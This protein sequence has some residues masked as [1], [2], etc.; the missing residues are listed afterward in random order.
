[1]TRARLSVGLVSP[2]PPVRSGIADYAKELVVPLREHV[3]LTTFAPAQAARAVESSCDVLLF[4]VGNDPL[5]LP[6]VEALR[7]RRKPAVVV[8]HD[9]VLHHLFA[10][11]YLDHGHLD[12][13]ER[14]LVRCHGLDGGEL[15]AKARSG[16]A[17]PVWDLSP[18]TFPMSAGVI[19][20]ATALLV[21]SRLVRG[22]VLRARPACHVVEIP[23]HVV[24]APVTPCDEARRRLGIPRDRPVAVT[25]GIVTPA[26]RVSKVLEALAA[27]PEA[28]RP[29]LVVGGAVGTEDPLHAQV[30]SLGLAADVLFTGYLSDDDFWV[31]ASAADLAVNLRHPTMGETSGAVCRLAGFGLPVVVSDV[32][33]FRELPDAFAIK[34][35]VGDGEVELLARTLASLGDPVWKRRSEAA[36]AWGLERSPERVAARYS[37]VLHDVAGGR[38]GEREL[39]AFLASQLSALGVGAGGRSPSRGPDGALLA[40]VAALAA[41]LLRA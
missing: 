27:V 34:V 41:P 37:E 40:G 7:E 29:F 28:S 1:V 26:K 19:A 5:H 25:L 39:T 12:R 33:W 38:S 36:R 14:E 9:F 18:W 30:E 32:G 31:A 23:H 3:D 10:A 20:D 13:Y 22:A 15:A 24:P 6:S 2:L 21:H 16:A 8:L 11:G 17:V 35:P 4:Q